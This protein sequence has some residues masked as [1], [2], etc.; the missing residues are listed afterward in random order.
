MTQT[1]NLRFTVVVDS[2]AVIARDGTAMAR[3]LADKAKENGMDIGEPRY[4]GASPKIGYA[5]AYYD[6]FNIDPDSAMWLRMMTSA[7]D[8]LR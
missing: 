1:Y 7:S 4:A 5:E 3:G 6:C 8:I 2:I